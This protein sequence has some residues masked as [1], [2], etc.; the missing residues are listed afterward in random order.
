MILRRHAASAVFAGMAVV[1]SF[2][3][4]HAALCGTHLLPVDNMVVMY[5][6]MAV[7][8][9]PAWLEKVRA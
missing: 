1:S 4:T 8:S 9:H 5:A 2:D 6:L 7:F 3:H